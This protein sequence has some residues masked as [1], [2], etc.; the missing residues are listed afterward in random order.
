M[1]V[2]GGGKITSLSKARSS[3]AKNLRFGTKIHTHT[4]V[5]SE[6]ISLSTKTPLVF[7]MSAFF[8]KTSEFFLAKRVPL[9]NGIIWELR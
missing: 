1:Q 3:Y 8:C 6:S 9:L 2:G 7:L 4:H 5:V